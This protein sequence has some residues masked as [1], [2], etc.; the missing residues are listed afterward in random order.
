V[1]SG[2]QAGNFQNTF[3]VYDRDGQ[4]CSGCGS[5]V[6]IIRQGNRSTFYCV[7]CQR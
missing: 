2:G 4:P 3:R 6:R 1:D 5:S 7:K